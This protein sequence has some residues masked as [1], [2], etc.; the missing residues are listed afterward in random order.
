MG[1][2]IGKI[3]RVEAPGVFVEIRALAPGREW[4]PCRFTYLGPLVGEECVVVETSP[5]VWVVVGPVSS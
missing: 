1:A 2:Q 4:G 5:D 3:T